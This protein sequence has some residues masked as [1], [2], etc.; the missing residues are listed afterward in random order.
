LERLFDFEPLAV[1]EEWAV[2]YPQ[3]IPVAVVEAG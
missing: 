1:E 2:L 3:L